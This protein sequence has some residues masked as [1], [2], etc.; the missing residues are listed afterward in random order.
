MTLE[1]AE[2]KEMVLDKEIS[3]KQKQLILAELR[4]NDLTLKSF[5]GSLKAALNWLG[6]HRRTS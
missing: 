2:N 5:G 3:I 1:E 4:K 6:T